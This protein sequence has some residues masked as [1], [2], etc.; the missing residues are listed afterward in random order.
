MLFGNSSKEGSS[1]SNPPKGTP[2]VTSTPPGPPQ[3]GP[4][5]TVLGMPTP[6]NA[7]RSP[8]ETADNAA[9]AKGKP[10]ASVGQA[11]TMLGISPLAA[12]GT[13]TQGTPAVTQPVSQAPEPLPS[14]PP[15]ARVVS[16][17]KSGQPAPKPVSHA[18]RNMTVLGM[19]A[20]TTETGKRESTQ[21]GTPR[22]L[23]EQA[24]APRPGL[25]STPSEPA[26]SPRKVP[27]TEPMPALRDSPVPETRP[28]TRPEPGQRPFPSEESIDAWGEEAAEESVVGR[29]QGMLLALVAAGAIAVIAAGLVIYLLL[30]SRAPALSPQVFPSPDG[31]SVTVILGFAEAPPGTTVQLAGQTAPVTQGSARVAIPMSS[32]KLGT[33]DVI[34]SYIEPGESPTQMTFPIVLRHAIKDDLTGLAAEKP[35]VDVHFQV[36]PGVGLAVEGKPAQLGAGTFTHR[37]DLNA[38]TAPAKG[39]TDYIMHKVSFQLTNPSGVAEQGEHLVAIPVTKLQIDRPADNATVASEEITCSGTAESGS[40]VQ[41]NGK[42][43]GITAL[44]FNTRVALPTTGEN[45][46]TVTARAPGKAPRT[47]VVRVR[48]VESLDGVIAEWSK[49]LDDQLD[50]PTLGRDPNALMDK[51]IRLTGRVVNISTERGVTAFILYVGKGCPAQAQCGVYVV[52]RG[53]TDAG[54]QSWVNVLGTVKGSRTVDLADGRKMEM[55]ALEAAFVVK[56]E[57]DEKQKSKGK[58]KR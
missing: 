29:S 39:E 2:A 31:S 35:F 57:T 23:G 20:P 51:K 12:A 19:P 5:K 8:T 58:N 25:E 40:Q 9:A 50:Y 47:E 36:A 52:L 37:I 30:F 46:I 42:T 38:M 3:G 43:A 44:G 53:E 16:S 15:M 41:V 10:P 49:D 24:E 22:A 11:K 34:V 21:R 18:S 45:R 27:G 48:R 26:P 56:V 33:N 55:P 13:T 4:A 54:L 6:S 28:H 32:L 7:P 17:G 1:Q 14:T